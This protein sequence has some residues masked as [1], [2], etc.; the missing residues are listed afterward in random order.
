[1][2]PPVR[3]SPD[4]EVVRPD[5]GQTIEQLNEAFDTILTRIAEHSGHAV[6]SVHAKSHG[7]LEGT[8][9]VDAGL[10]P[11]LAQGLFA[12]AGEHK[13]NMRMSTN[14]GDIL[15]DSV[16]LPRGLALK[17]LNVVG[18]RLPDAEGTTQDFVMVNGPVFQAPNAETF[19]GSLKLLAKTTDRI[20]GVKVA[21][22]TVLRGVN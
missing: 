5:E 1:M 22:S 14:A 3:Y 2:Q 7:I 4:V 19:L 15:P 18:E 6:R 13:V 9:T 21:A 8:L 17:V 16:S 11:E 10:P 12:K 20:E